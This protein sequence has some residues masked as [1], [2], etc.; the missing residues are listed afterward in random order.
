MDKNKSVDEF[1][2]TKPNW[3]DELEILRSILCSTE[4]VETVKWGMPTYT[5]NEKNVVGLGAFKSYVGIWFHQ[6][7][8]LN[9][10]HKVLINA[11]EGK[12]KGLR[13]WRFH[14]MNEINKD[15]VLEYVK[16]AIQNQKNAKEIKPKK[17]KVLKIPAELDNALSSND[18]LKECF[19][20]LTSG[21]QK[22]FIEYISTAKRETTRLSRL[23]KIIP[24]II[25]GEGLHDKYR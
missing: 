13:Q 14:S 25:N 22:E 6:G 3:K 5:I 11:Q 20:Q 24:M 18:K 7:V 16:E 1:I 23:E 17:S 21:K 4:L 15:L 9:D 8:F 10:A 2:A 12:T 19:K